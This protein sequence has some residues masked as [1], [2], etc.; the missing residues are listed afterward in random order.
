MVLADKRLKLAPVPYSLPVWPI[1]KTQPE[2]KILFSSFCLTHT[3]TSPS[4]PRRV[5]PRRLHK[6]RNKRRASRH[7][8]RLG[9]G[10]EE[11]R[12][13]PAELQTSQSTSRFSCEWRRRV[14]CCVSAPGEARLDT[15][16]KPWSYGEVSL[17]AQALWNI[18]LKVV[19]LQQITYSSLV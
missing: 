18:F 15:T 4:P 13:D 1:K 17:W 6:P 8:G 14:T 2:V 19:K 11:E 7:A 12:G 9:S 5:C 3:T 10:G 16:G